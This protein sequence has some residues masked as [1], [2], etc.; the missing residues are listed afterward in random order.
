MSFIFIHFI[1]WMNILAII[2]FKALII[3]YLFFYVIKLH[4]ENC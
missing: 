2:K 4:L 3:V 1:P